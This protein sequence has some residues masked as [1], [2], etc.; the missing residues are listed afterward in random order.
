MWASVKHLC[1]I[2]HGE[3]LLSFGRLKLVR[4][5]EYKITVLA[6][7][8]ARSEWQLLLKRHGIIETLSIN[9][10][11]GSRTRQMWGIEVP[12]WF[13][14]KSSRDFLRALSFPL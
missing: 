2:T 11:K 3:Y 5:A 1:I 4:C 14:Q 9:L 8:V 10:M 12:I 6:R 7:D 13:A